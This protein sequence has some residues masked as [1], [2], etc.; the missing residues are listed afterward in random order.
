MILP[1]KRTPIDTPDAVELTPVFRSRRLPRAVF[2]ADLSSFYV[3]PDDL[4]P[5]D[6][7]WRG[8]R[9]VS[10][11]PALRP[12]ARSNGLDPTPA[13]GYWCLLAMAGFIV[14]FAAAAIARVWGLL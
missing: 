2:E 14:G 11:F 3:L 13:V 8:P 9:E 12:E 1:G 6:A 5:P 7:G 10:I 4:P